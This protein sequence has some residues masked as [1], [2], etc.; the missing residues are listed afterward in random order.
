MINLLLDDSTIY[1]GTRKDVFTEKLSLLFERFK[2]AGDTELKFYKGN[3]GCENCQCTGRGYSFVGNC[4]GKYTDFVFEEHG[5]TYTDII[6]CNNLL[7]DKERY[8]PGGKLIISFC[9][10]ELD[11]FVPS[12][13]Y[14]INCQKCDAAVEEIMA[15]DGSVVPKELYLFWF[16]KYKKIYKKVR[17]KYTNHSAFKKFELLFWDLKDIIK[18][19]RLLSD[20]ENA[21]WE[22]H[23]AADD[24]DADEWLEDH[25]RAGRHSPVFLFNVKAAQRTIRLPRTPVLSIVNS[26]GGYL[27][28]MEI[29]NLHSPEIEDDYDFYDEPKDGR[30]TL[31]WF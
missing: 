25:Y 3:G 17:R 23:Q 1:N 18:T 2:A 9:D 4:S 31:Q 5:S 21:V 14:L 29:Y 16:D 8:L 10:D 27:K 12:L 22:Y 6:C 11:G 13:K 20:A 7:S 30:K 19:C 28:F 26:F 24:F 15:Y